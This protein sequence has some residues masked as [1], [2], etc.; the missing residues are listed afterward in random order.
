[1]DKCMCARLL[2]AETQVRTANYDT[3]YYST[4]AEYQNPVSSDS[5]EAVILIGKWKST[6]TY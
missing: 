5:W 2:I 3:L 6:H 4:L 1:M